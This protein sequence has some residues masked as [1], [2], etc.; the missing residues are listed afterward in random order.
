MTKFVLRFLAKKGTVCYADKKEGKSN[1][2][3]CFKTV[4]EK[5]YIIEFLSDNDFTENQNK[6]IDKYISTIQT[7]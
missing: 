3:F 2:V 5:A 7:A 6:R 4:G 1:G